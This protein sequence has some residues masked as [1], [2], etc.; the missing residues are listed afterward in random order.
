M[1]AKTIKVEQL[2]LILRL[3]ESGYSKKGITR[4]TGLAPNTVRK[5]LLKASSELVTKMIEAYQKKFQEK[6]EDNPTEGSIDP[7][8][9]SIST[10]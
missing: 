5:Y 4:T 3:H 6:Q 10:R 9:L 8:A 2:K 7:E 1:A